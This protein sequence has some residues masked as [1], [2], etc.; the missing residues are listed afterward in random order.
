MKRLLLILALT[1][2]AMASADE[3]HTVEWFRD[4]A[5]AR[6]AQVFW[7]NNN[8]GLARRVPNCQN[9]ID[10]DALAWGRAKAAAAHEWIPGTQGTLAYACKVQRDLGNQATTPLAPICRELKAPGY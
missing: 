6:R 1:A 5:E 10:G 9:A 8:A 2:P 7:C 4:H 3:Y